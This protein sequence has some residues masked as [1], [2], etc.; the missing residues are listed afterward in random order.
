MKIG[1][2]GDGPWAHLALEKLSLDDRFE[3]A[4]IVPRFDNQ[5]PV[6]KKWANKLGVPFLGLK[7][8]N[9][10]ESL[11]I[12]S[13]FKTDLNISMSYNQILRKNILK[14]APKGFINCHAGELPFYRG[15]NVLTWA[16]IND[17]PKFGVTVHYVDEGID[18]G[19]IIKQQT[20]EITDSDDYC[21]LLERAS[22][23]CSEI[24]FDAVCSIQKGIVRRQPQLEIHPVGFYCSRR[25]PG[26]E[27]IDW[28]M[29]SRQLFNFARALSS[30]G[31]VARTFIGSCEIYIESIE[32]IKDAPVYIGIPGSVVALHNG[33]PVVKSGDSTVLVTKLKEGDL[34][35]IKVGQRLESK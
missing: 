34:S 12:L 30:P 17:E 32:E 15:R 5:D 8:V 29:N 24:L 10:T 26:D 2:F 14:L 23:I 3:I 18:T 1:Y 22:I 7:N 25:K 21:S 35:D 33:C 19:D 20:S 28:S 27:I 31:P 11:S 4:Y 9:A 6:L 13:K 16:L